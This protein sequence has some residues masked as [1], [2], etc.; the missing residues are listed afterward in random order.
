MNEPAQ[1]LVASDYHTEAL[2]SEAGQ[3]KDLAVHRTPD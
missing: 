2:P 1:G 3:A